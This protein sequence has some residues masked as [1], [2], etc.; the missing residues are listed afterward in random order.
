[1]KVLFAGDLSS[2]GRIKGALQS[3]AQAGLF[4]EIA[5][6]VRGSD[7]SVLN[8]ETPIVRDGSLMP[9]PK[10]G[11]H[12]SAPSELLDLVTSCGFRCA[13]LANNHI[14]DYGG[15]ALLDTM[16]LLR[17]KQIDYVG[18]GKNLDEAAEVLIKQIGN[19][20]LAII[21]ICESC[22]SIAG[23]DSPGAYP[24]DV[25]KNLRQID[26]AKNNADYIVVIV[27]GGVELY[28]LPTPRMKELYR[29][30]I[31][32]GADAV[33][34]HH[35]HC[36][37]GYEVYKDKPIFYGLGNLCMDKP[38]YPNQRWYN[39]FLLL[40]DFGPSV[41]FEI[42]P[43]IQNKESL[44]VTL[45]RGEEADVVMKDIASL[46][47][48]ISDDAALNSS[49]AKVVH[50]KQKQVCFRFSPYSGKIMTYLA[51]KGLLKVKPGNKRLLRMQESLMNDTHRELANNVFSSLI[52]K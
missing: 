16:S 9:I 46:S 12:L 15:E 13:T 24:V 52:K 39:G 40:V 30:F 28:P 43:Y 6:V 17:T 22:F 5:P 10:V 26:Y 8:L 47:Q 37:S 2:S 18:A 49:F 27:H 38:G 4:D 44:G 34:N 41:D 29:F 51:Q 7:Y 31:D 50:N 23:I 25:V 14:M 36:Y 3:G 35:Q 21:N 11:P 33:V 20:R 45:L 42:I 19:Q 1:M 48:T 32:M